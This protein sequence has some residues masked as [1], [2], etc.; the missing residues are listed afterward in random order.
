MIPITL[1]AATIYGVRIKLVV[2]L[3]SVSSSL[4]GGLAGWAGAV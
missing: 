4:L 3:V 1:L 2:L